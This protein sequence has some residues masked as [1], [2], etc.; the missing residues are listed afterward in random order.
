MLI[1]LSLVGIVALAFTYSVIAHGAG[2][3]SRRL[4]TPCLCRRLF[5][6]CLVCAR[7]DSASSL[8]APWSSG[9]WR[10]SLTATGRLR[11]R[12]SRGLAVSRSGPG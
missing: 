3:R 1:A 9:R 10:N 7:A 8:Y 4:L 12:P 2:G 11:R 5:T 6:K